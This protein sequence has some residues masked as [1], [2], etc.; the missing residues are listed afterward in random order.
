MK[1]K[2]EPPVPRNEWPDIL[3]A[4]DLSDLMRGWLGINRT[5][6]IFRTGAF[7]VQKIGQSHVIS[8]VDFFTWFDGSDLWERCIKT[9]D[10]LWD[11]SEEYITVK[12]PVDSIK[13]LPVEVKKLL[14]K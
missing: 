8:T 12:I 13:K 5:Y 7:P 6:E 3:T 9:V 4:Q 10:A 11:E 2:F 14:K 1:R